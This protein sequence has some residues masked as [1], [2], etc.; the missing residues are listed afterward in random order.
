MTTRSGTRAR[1]A[2]PPLE[3]AGIGSAGARDPLSVEV[4]LLGALLGEVIEEQAGKPTFQLVELLRRAAISLRRRDDPAERAWLEAE[5]EE[6]DLGAMEAVINAFS[7]YFQLVN[8]A[9][10]RA[11]VRTLRRRER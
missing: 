1:T 6:L 7:L 11:R 3:P 8:L 4:R 10:T 5:L 9:E 2:I